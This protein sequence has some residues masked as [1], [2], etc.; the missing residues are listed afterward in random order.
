MLILAIDTS[1]DETS[2]AVLR[3]DRVLSNVVWSQIKIHQ[4]WGGVVP[5]LARRAHE[6]RLPAV[7]ASAL[8]RYNSY[9]IYNN[10]K[11]YSPI[12]AV[13]VTVGPGLA[14]ALE[15]GIKFA[16]EYVLKNKIPLIPVNHLE[17]HIASV[18][19]RNRFGSPYTPHISQFPHIPG[20]FLSLIV[21]GG[22][23]ELIVSVLPKSLTP[24]TSSNFLAVSHS[25]L[26][27]SLDDAAGECLDKVG[28]E[29]GLGYPAAPVIERL[30]VDFAKKYSSSRGLAR[31]LAKR[32]KLPVALIASPQT[33]LNFS[34]SGLKSAAVRSISKNSF[35]RLNFASQKFGGPKSRISA[36][37]FSFQ[38]AVINSILLKL[39]RAVIQTGIKTVCLSGGVAANNRLRHLVY[40]EMKKLG[41]KVYLAPKKPASR[42][43]GGFTGDNAAMI[44]LAGLWAYNRGEAARTPKEIQKVDR[45][46]GLNFPS[47]PS[48]S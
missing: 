6:E 15:V 25:L 31:D 26:G 33:D 16:K 20:C 18:F 42:A 34:F 5:N 13:A 41:V 21:S 1:C 38:Q 44:G 45:L 10:Y 36:F 9:K 11:S 43:S 32:Y 27:Q 46:P 17:G 47:A 22:H 48:H 39:R 23:T 2:A 24:P 29:L 37:C 14:P 30:A 35:T 3:N 12:S 28:R 8:A 40:Y 19:L 7:V 4:K